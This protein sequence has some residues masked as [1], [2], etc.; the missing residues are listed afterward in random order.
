M[1]LSG[2]PAKGVSYEQCVVGFADAAV[3]GAA[4]GAE[5][6][7]DP[8]VADD[9]NASLGVGEGE[10][11]GLPRRGGAPGRLIRR[12]AVSV[13]RGAQDRTRPVD[14]FADDVPDW[15]AAG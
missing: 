14:R 2:E 3:G 5:G 13:F 1:N 7:R 10:D 9:D 4:G 8:R 15:R 6:A 11:D 12:P